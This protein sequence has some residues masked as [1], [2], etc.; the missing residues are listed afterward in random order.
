LKVLTSK[1]LAER[2]GIR[3]GTLRNWRY[4]G[5]GPAFMKVGRSIRYRLADV[6]YH[7]K[8]MKK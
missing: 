5:V 3:E 1:Q 2:W 8:A 7:E 6:V 4:Q